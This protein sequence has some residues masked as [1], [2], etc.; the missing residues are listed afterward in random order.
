M[1]R[2]RLI[3]K[4]LRRGLEPPLIYKRA[5]IES[6]GRT[7]AIIRRLAGAQ[8]FFA[9]GIALYYLETGCR[10]ARAISQAFDLSPAARLMWIEF[11][12]DSRAEHSPFGPARGAAAL[13]ESYEIAASAE[14]ASRASGVPLAEMERAGARLWQTMLTF[15]DSKM[16]ATVSWELP[17]SGWFVT[18]EG[19]FWM[20]EPHPL[21][22]Y[23]ALDGELLSEHDLTGELLAPT[24]ACSVAALALSFLN[25]CEPLLSRFTPGQPGPETKTLAAC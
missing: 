22:T 12:F 5:G 4:I 23:P 3:D 6:K 10:G 7:T 21:L 16:G 15:R 14:T 17:V 9:D 8:R 19:K 11:L 24:P 13:I 2:I 20:P 18:E 1:G 25:G